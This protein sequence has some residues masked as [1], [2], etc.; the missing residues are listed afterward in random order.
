MPAA[1]ISHS[2]NRRLG[3]ERGFENTFGFRE[4]LPVIF[5]GTKD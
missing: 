3:H 5:C 1:K 2:T 4:K